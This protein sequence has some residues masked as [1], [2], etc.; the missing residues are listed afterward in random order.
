MWPCKLRTF[1]L[2]FRLSHNA[3]VESSEHVA[4][5]QSDRNLETVREKKHLSCE[6]EHN[7]NNRWNWVEMATYLTQLTESWC[8]F[9]TAFVW[10]LVIGSNSTIDRFSHAAINSL[11]NRYQGEKNHNQWARNL[12]SK[13]KIIRLRKINW[14]LP[15]WWIFQVIYA[16]IFGTIFRITIPAAIWLEMCKYRFMDFVFEASTEFESAFSFIVEWKYTHSNAEWW[17]IDLGFLQCTKCCCT[18]QSRTMFLCVYRLL[19]LVLCLQFRLDAYLNKKY[20]NAVVK[21]PMLEPFEVNGFLAQ[22]I[23]IPFFR[24][25][26]QI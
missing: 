7:P 8:A 15:V 2:R 14:Q 25:Y 9:F 17:Q 18:I 24:Q 1:V 11:L 21:N 6:M 20:L 22:R 4:N 3:T 16:T 26:F 19:L 23:D 10:R 12:A 13:C 5:K